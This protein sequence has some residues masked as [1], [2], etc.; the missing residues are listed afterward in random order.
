MEQR[1]EKWAD[2]RIKAEVKHQKEREKK[3][4][5]LFRKRDPN[6]TLL[7]PNFNALEQMAQHRKHD[8]ERRRAHEQKE[9]AAEKARVREERAK[10]K[11][12]GRIDELKV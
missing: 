4:S 9:W 8:D 5:F 1:R 10:E 11:R 2:A 3:A 7:A 12:A 6:L